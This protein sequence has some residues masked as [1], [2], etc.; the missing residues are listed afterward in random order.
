MS[1]WHYW[2]MKGKSDQLQQL[3]LDSKTAKKRQKSSKFDWILDGTSV[4]GTTAE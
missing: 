1:R 2:S 4:N 3:I